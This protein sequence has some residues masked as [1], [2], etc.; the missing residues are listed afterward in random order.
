MA[1]GDHY[2]WLGADTAVQ[3][4]KCPLRDAVEQAKLC[5]ERVRLE[6]VEQQLDRAYDILFAIPEHHP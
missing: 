4:G 2:F 1:R 3:C 6:V 5:L